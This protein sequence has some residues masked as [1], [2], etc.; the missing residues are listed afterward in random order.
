MHMLSNNECKSALQ[1]VSFPSRDLVS[2]SLFLYVWLYTEVSRNLGQ[3]LLIL[4]KCSI[5]LRR[6][7]FDSNNILKIIYLFNEHWCFACIYTCLCEG[8]RY[9]GTR[10]TTDSCKLSYGYCDLNPGPLKEQ[11]VL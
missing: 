5:Y 8:V 2:L 10:V 11:P 3:R 9:S 7:N 6:H 4:H 1:H